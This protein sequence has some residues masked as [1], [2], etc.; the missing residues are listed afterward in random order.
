MYDVLLSA[1]Y[2]QCK[3]QV[4]EF[5]LIAVYPLTIYPS[6]EGQTNSN[7]IFGTSKVLE[8]VHLLMIEL[9]HPNFG[10]ERT[11]HRT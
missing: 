1:G 6:I 4:R 8:H 11:E 5:D 10:F 2:K 7:V 9:K 3:N